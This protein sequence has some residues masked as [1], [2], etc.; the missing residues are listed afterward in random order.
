MIEPLF[1]AD[2]PDFL[3]LPIK[4][5]AVLGAA[6]LGGWCL[7]LVATALSRAYFAQKI[8]PRPMWFIRTAGFLACGLLGYWWLFG[9]G[10]A[11]IGGGGGIF[12]GAGGGPKEGVVKQKD[13]TTGKDRDKEKDKAD[14]EDKDKDR[15]KV[16]PDETLRVEVLGDAALKKIA[17]RDDFDGA[18]RYR[19]AGK[20]DLLTLEGVKALVKKRRS[21]GPTLGKL[22]IV[23][24]ADSPAR[25]RPL[26]AELESWAKDLPEERQPL[27]VTVSDE[28]GNAPVN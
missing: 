12:G 5:L 19:A 21:D 18:K 3:L 14:K 11:G 1:A 16:P 15:A 17:R 8:P 4:I 7:G 22:E 23:L 24:Y 26:V 2:I 20:R 9:G 10:G 13:E 6:T 28:E 27:T 25:D